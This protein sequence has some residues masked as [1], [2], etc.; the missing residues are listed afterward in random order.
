MFF[1]FIHE[2]V[3]HICAVTQQRRGLI[4]WPTI[5]GYRVFVPTFVFAMKRTNDYTKDLQDSSCS[6][7]LTESSLINFYMH[8]LFERTSVHNI[9]ATL[10]TTSY[11]PA[12]IFGH[13]HYL[14]FV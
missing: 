13:S 5:R 10:S 4:D 6:L 7:L 9:M 3:Q 11:W 12:S 14:V 8:H 1:M 2:W